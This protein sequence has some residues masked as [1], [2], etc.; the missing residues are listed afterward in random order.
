MY[1]ETMIPEEKGMARV[2]EVKEVIGTIQTA[3]AEASATIVENLHTPM[4]RYVFWL[5]DLGKCG[6]F[7]MSL[8]SLDRDKA[9]V[10]A[11]DDAEAFRSK[12]NCRSA[13]QKRVD[14][15]ICEARKKIEEWTNP[16]GEASVLQGFRE[17][18][19]QRIED[20]CEKLE[21]IRTPE[22]TSIVDEMSDYLKTSEIHKEAKKICDNLV[23]KYQL[24]ENNVYYGEICYDVWDPSDFEDG[25]AK[26]IAKGF[27]RHGFDCLEAIRSIEIDAI[28]VL[29]NFQDDFNAQIQD[30]ILERIV[31]PIQ[32]LIP[33]LRTKTNQ[34]SA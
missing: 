1:D 5:Q 25:F 32:A 13:A 23:G 10:M 17:L 30:E 12:M 9:N 33:Q 19:D 11:A 22:N 28:D 15:A 18:F 14:Q 21:V 3:A 24:R 34:L 7:Q 29:G 6:S 20:L 8:V 26:L 2:E 16:V 4:E 31:E 27:I